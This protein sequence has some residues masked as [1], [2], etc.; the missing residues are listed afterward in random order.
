VASSEWESWIRSWK[1]CFTRPSW[2]LFQELTWAWILCPGRRTAT[3]MISILPRAHAHDAYHRFL[4]V[5]S[6]SMAK[7]WEILA[8]ALVTAFGEGRIVLDLDDTL[9]RKTGR[10]IEGAGLFR[11]PVR[12]SGRGIVYARGLS[13]VVLTLRVTPPWGG[14]PLGLPINMRLHRKKAATYLELAIEML[15]EVAGWFPERGFALFCDGAYASLVGVALPRTVVTSRLRRDAA[16]YEVPQRSKKSLRGRPTKKGRRFPNPERMAKQSRIQW[17]RAEVDSRGQEQEC[18]LY[19]RSVLWYHVCPDR[20]VLLVIARDPKGRRPDDFLVTTDL[21]SAPAQVV[22]QYTGRW[23]IE[24]TFRNVKQFLGGEDPQTWKHQGPE[25]AA[26]LSLWLY[27]EIW[28]CYI[29]TRGCKITWPT[30]PWYTSKKTPSFLD[31]LSDLR[32]TL[33]REMIFQK[34]A[35]QSLSAKNIRPLIEALARAA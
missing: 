34:S 25:R 20:P 9:F 23:S 33:W 21:E 29:K 35:P 24:D 10:K 16:L 31:A 27:A 14:E 7:L 19:W 1:P 12:T 32:R 15:R 11:D 13:L 6:W 26:A 22:S 2:A 17:T 4:R 5:G 8:R 3:H 28:L 30:L 18:F